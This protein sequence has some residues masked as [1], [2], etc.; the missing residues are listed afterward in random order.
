M[1][2][3]LGQEA[4]LPAESADVLNDHFINVGERTSDTWN[5]PVLPPLPSSPPPLNAISISS[6]IVYKSI[7]KLPNGKAPGIDGI[8]NEI[9]QKSSD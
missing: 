8:T 6:S 2:S 4:V 5:L 7:K 1:I 3:R 9:L